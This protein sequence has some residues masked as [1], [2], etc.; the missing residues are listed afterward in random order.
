MFFVVMLTLASAGFVS[1]QNVFDIGEVSVSNTDD[2]R[3]M[4]VDSRSRQPLNGRNKVIVGARTEYMQAV[5]ADGIYS[6]DFEY[7]KNDKLTEKGNC[8]EGLKEGIWAEYYPDGETVRRQVTYL[9]GKLTGEV[10][11]YDKNG[12]LAAVKI[13]KDGAE[14]GFQRFYDPESGEVRA[15]MNYKDGRPNG[16]QRTYKTVVTGKVKQRIVIESEYRN[17]VKVGEDKEFVFNNAKGRDE[18]KDKNKDG[19]RNA[20]SVTLKRNSS[21]DGQ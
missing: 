7:Y 4:Y 18:S 19:K 11:E 5:F 8:V 20:H 21:P 1:A 10:R 16:L 3:K 13:Y 14:N 15:E 12:N 17:G 9:A 2:G 6:G